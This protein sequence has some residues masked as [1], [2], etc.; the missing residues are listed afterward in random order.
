MQGY[1]VVFDV[2]NV[3]FAPW[4]A[5]WPFALAI[6]L[7]L[8]VLSII[9]LVFSPR[10]RASLRAYRLFLSWLAALAVLAS[11]ATIAIKRRQYTQMLKWEAEHQYRVVEGIVTNF[12]PEGP[13]GH[14]V[15]SF[16]V[17]GISFFYST[18][19]DTP[20]F[21]W[22]ARAGG[23]VRDGLQVRIAEHQGAILRLEILPSPV[24]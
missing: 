16:S 2:A 13:G 23:P 4:R 8:G 7:A 5:A 10:E 24:H 22:S 17:N 14:P 3:S 19:F 15:E 12:V 11:A 18:A 9:R 21:H 6:I 1:K 20:A